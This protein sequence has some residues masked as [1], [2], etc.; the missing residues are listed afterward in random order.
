M[1]FVER[2]VVKTCGSLSEIVE[3][4]RKAEASTGTAVVRKF[5]AAVTVYDE[6]REYFK[7]LSAIAG[8]D[9]DK[10]F[11]FFNEGVNG[12]DTQEQLIKWMD[13]LH[14]V[15]IN[16]DLKE[17]RLLALMIYRILLRLAMYIVCIQK[18]DMMIAK[19]KMDALFERVVGHVKQWITV[20]RR[21]K[22]FGFIKGMVM[23]LSEE[24]QQVNTNGE[25]S[26]KDK[27]LSILKLISEGLSK[28]Q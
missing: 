1:E 21:L 17:F 5:R 27:Y 12:A 10:H 7:K 14:A 18:E 26:A 15:I 24:I 28:I 23:M 3:S 4:L 25:G 6:I 9:A 8:G 22:L 13:A 20:N 19:V 16:P 2:T 11:Q